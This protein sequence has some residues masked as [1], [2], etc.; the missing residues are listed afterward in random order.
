M[1]DVLRCWCATCGKQAGRVV[2]NGDGELVFEGIER[3][4]S[5]RLMRRLG[6]NAARP[7][8][9]RNMPSVIVLP[10]P[11]GEG[12]RVSTACRGG[13]EL[14]ADLVELVRDHRSGRRSVVL[15]PMKRYAVD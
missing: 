1:S 11:D 9:W 4:N 14:I 5:A 8:E 12:D 7:D 10:E 6:I 2:R 3:F 13:H 15:Q